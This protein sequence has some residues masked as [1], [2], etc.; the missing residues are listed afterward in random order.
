[1]TQWPI[2]NSLKSLRGFLGLVGY[3]R[4]FIKD[5]GK[6]SQPLTDLLKKNSFFWNKEAEDAFNNLKT[7]MCRALVLVMPN[8][9]KEFKIECDA[10]GG[11][12]GV[13]LLQEG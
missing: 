4:R 9:Q 5:Y 7:T 2:P 13:V 10:A 8:F 3:Y 11:G 1:M 6:I 12:I